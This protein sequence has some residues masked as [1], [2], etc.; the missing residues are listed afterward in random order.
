MNGKLQ[1][2]ET[3]DD[4]TD[5]DYVQDYVI[6]KMTKD[7]LYLYNEEESFE[8]GRYVP[9]PEEDLGIDLDYDSEESFDLW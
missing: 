9:E 1:V 7:S 5:I 2:V 3:R 8:F 4:G 6:V